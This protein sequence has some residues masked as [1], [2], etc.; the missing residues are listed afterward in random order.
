MFCVWCIFSVCVI[1]VRYVYGISVVCVHYM[2]RVCFCY[3]CG[4]CYIKNVCD[5]WA[6]CF[7]HDW[8][9]CG[10]CVWCMCFMYDVSLVCFVPVWFMCVVHML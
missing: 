5:V 2:L 7:L 4:V 3:V 9:F 10:V 1:H 8:W 6:V